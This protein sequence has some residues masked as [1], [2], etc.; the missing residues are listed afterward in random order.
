M[1]RNIFHESSTKLTVWFFAMFLMTSTRHGVAAKEI[2]RKTDDLSGANLERIVADNVEKGSVV[3]TD[4]WP[5][6]IASANL[7]STTV[8]SITLKMNG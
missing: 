7:G 5:D 6:I 3:S 1:C 8:A 2:E 4:E